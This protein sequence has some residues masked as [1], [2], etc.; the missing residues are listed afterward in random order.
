MKDI[1]ISLPS[2][3]KDTLDEIYDHKVC[4][5]LLLMVTFLNALTHSWLVLQQERFRKGIEGR[6]H[7][8]SNV[9]A[10]HDAIWVDSYDN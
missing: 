4:S 6:L 1:P 8:P 5:W 7:I 10:H 3:E 9:F 2:I